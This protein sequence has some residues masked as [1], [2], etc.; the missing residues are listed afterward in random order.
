MLVQMMV[1]MI[2]SGRDV[3]GGSGGDGNGGS[4]GSCW[5]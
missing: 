1:V 4:D 3:G 2:G 5:R